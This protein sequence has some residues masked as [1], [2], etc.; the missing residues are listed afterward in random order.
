[1]YSSFLNNKGDPTLISLAHF[2][3]KM[4]ELPLQLP[5]FIATAMIIQTEIIFHSLINRRRRVLLFHIQSQSCS[6]FLCC[7][8]CID[9]AFQCI[10]IGAYRVAHCKDNEGKTKLLEMDLSEFCAAFEMMY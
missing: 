7:T 10:C 5:Q 9:N 6:L 1:M 4:F 3:W 2:Y 8:N